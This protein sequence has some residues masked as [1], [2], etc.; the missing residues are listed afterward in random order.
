MYPDEPGESSSET[1]PRLVMKAGRTN[2]IQT[3]A[4][5]LS[6]SLCCFDIIIFNIMRQNKPI[7]ALAESEH[8]VEITNSTLRNRF[9]LRSDLSRS[10]KEAIENRPNK[11]G[12]EKNEFDLQRYRLV[13]I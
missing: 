12:S 7:N 6:P 1:L 11:E 5:S 3:I 2:T 13:L 9:F 4:M 8:T 10:T